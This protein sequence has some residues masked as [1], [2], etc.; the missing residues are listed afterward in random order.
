M[1]RAYFNSDGKGRIHLLT[2]DVKRA[3][4]DAK[5]KN[6]IITITSNLA[7]IGVL[8]GEN[9]KTLQEEY[10]KQCYGAFHELEE[11]SVNRRS[12]SSPDKY[13]FM[14]MSVGTSLTL[15]FQQG[16]LLLSPFQDVLAFDFELSPG[17]REFMMAVMGAA[18]PAAAPPAR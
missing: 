18:E 10:F 6:G 2:H 5:A 11:K 17:R 16:K 9:D 1:H 13:H 15:A 7:T 8:T 3:L 4:I 14:A 12:R